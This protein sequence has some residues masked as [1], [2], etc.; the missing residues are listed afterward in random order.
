[1]ALYPAIVVVL[2]VLVAL[3][4]LMV[5]IPR[6]ASLYG[7]MGRGAAAG[8]ATS[9]LLSLSVVLRDHPMLVAGV[10][11]AGAL[12]VALLIHGGR[13]R[14]VAAWIVG[15]VP[16]LGLQLGHFDRARVY[17][18]LALLVKGG[19]SLHESMSICGELGGSDEVRSQLDQAR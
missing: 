16:W 3:F 17:E 1:A 7:E 2:G 18:A 19:Y 8:A 14:K 5:V 11:A 15:H 4:L 9:F 10:A 12:G 13:W 6:F